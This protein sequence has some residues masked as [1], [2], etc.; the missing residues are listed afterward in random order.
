M[1]ALFSLLEAD[2]IAHTMISTRALELRW[3]ADDSTKVAVTFPASSSSTISSC[4]NDMAETEVDSSPV[5]PLV[6]LSK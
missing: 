3:R 2:V 6:Q 1:S 4:G 5:Q